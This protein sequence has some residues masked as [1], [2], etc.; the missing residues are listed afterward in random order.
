RPGLTTI[1]TRRAARSTS[2][3]ARSG[4][5]GKCCSRD[6]TKAFSWQRK[7]LSLRHATSQNANGVLSPQPFLSRDCRATLISLE[8]WS[9]SDR[10]RL[11][12][13]LFGKLQEER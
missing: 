8:R 10:N 11:T 12:H 13:V 3:T 1:S 5:C 2:N 9:I 6:E 4:R 7:T